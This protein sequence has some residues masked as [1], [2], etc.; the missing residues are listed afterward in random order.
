MRKA[1]RRTLQWSLVALLLLQFTGCGTILYP[2]RR[3][4]SAGKLDAVV[5]ILDAVGLFFF[6]VPGV[7]AFAVDFSTGAVYLPH[8][9]RSDLEDIIGRAEIREYR[10]ESRELGDIVALVEAETGL[11]I[12]SRALQVLRGQRGD[13]VETRLRVL[14]AQTAMT[15]SE[16]RRAGS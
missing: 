10:L 13:A 4:Q 1:L 9:G 7:I 14:N 12:D 16:D 5:V 11:E 6:F 3:G 8:G 2:E 15:R